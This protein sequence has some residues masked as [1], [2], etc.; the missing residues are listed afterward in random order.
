MSFLSSHDGTETLRWQRYIDWKGAVFVFFLV[1][2]GID[3][4]QPQSRQE[5]EM[6]YTVIYWVELV[7]DE[8]KQV[9]NTSAKN[10]YFILESGE[11]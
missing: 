11:H 8:W 4:E 6:A 3:L 7:I 9:P 5:K 10:F 1:D 2:P